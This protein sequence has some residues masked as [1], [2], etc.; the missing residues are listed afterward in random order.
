MTEE[1]TCCV[2]SDD[3]LLM[4]RRLYLLQHNRLNFEETEL[5]SGLA[6]TEIDNELPA[7]HGSRAVGV[8]DG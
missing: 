6:T 3:L 4:C 1:G 5:F 8:R 2:H 7:G